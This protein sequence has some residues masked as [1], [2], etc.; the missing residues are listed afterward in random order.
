MNDLPGDFEQMRA[1]RV[2][3]GRYLLA[4]IAT[5]FAGL[6]SLLAV[7]AWKIVLILLI[8][9]TLF[10]GYA[11]GVYARNW[12]KEY[13]LNTGRPPEDAEL[14]SI[15]SGVSTGLAGTIAL[16]IV[17]YLAVVLFFHIGALV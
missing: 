2:R 16:A 5:I 15:L 3:Y 6:L 11:S 12:A 10:G 9:P 13:L 17:Q 7:T 14:G 4:C 8:A 1:K